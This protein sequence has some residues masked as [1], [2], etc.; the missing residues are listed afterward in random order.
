M[1]DKDKLLLSILSYLKDKSDFVFLWNGRI[2]D[3]NRYSFIFTSPIRYLY[4]NQKQEFLDTML[5]IESILHE[6][7]YLAGFISYNAGLHYENITSEGIKNDFPLLWLGV[8]RNPIVYDHI[9]GRLYGAEDLCLC[10]ESC[11]CSEYQIYD[12]ANS[13]DKCTYI[14]DINSVREAIAR[15]E[16]YQVNYTFKH[17]FKF[18]GDTSDLFSELCMKQ[19]A[20]YSAFIRCMNWDILSL[21][22]ELFFRRVGD[23]ITVKPMKGTI[24]R[25]INSPDDESKAQELYNST[26][27]RAENV[28]IV[29][30]LRNDIGRISK[31]GSVNVSK[32]Y[33]IEKYETLFQMTSTIESDLKEG[34]AWS[35]LFKSVFPSGSVTGAPKIST[36]QIINALEKEQR[37]IYTGSIGYIAPNND[38]VFNVAIRTAV[39]GRYDRNGEMGIGGGITYDSEAEDEFRESLLK[40][41]FLT[42][43]YR[44]FQLIET[45]LWDKSYYLLS[46]HLKRLE[47]SSEY[48]GFSFDEDRIIETLKIECEKFDSQSKYRVRLLLYRNGEISVSSEE[49]DEIIANKFTFS[50][51]KTDPENR[52]LYHKTTN[53]EVYNTELKRARSEGFYD[54]LFTNTRDEVTEGAI[55]NV[56]IKCGNRFYTPPINCGVLD[57]VYRRN[58]LESGF[59]LEEKLLLEE[60]VLRA[61]K[62][63]MV[64]SVRG[65]VEVLFI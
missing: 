11:R 59:P 19:S 49:L 5:S 18:I 47:G 31:I 50:K 30:L 54:I 45:M 43:R 36:M 8:Y 63:Y 24:K 4:C 53:R 37:G 64:N 28:M 41:S 52:F 1:L 62:V 40:A 29:D 16:T 26:K 51:I 38:S 42:S 22:P 10:P 32:L 44:D 12:C 6:G 27:N 48:F 65:M 17:K 21:S 34:V 35:D 3:D 56:I 15:G 60:D 61:D 58:L 23:H 7:Y 57:G 55:S 46:L 9:D 13:V 33:E 25:G 20:S 14:N 2:D 39:I